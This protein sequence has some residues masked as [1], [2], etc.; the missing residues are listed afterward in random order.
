M[1]IRIGTRMIG[2]IGLVGSS[3]GQ[4]QMI[5]ADEK[6]YMELIGQI[7]DFIATKAVEVEAAEKREILIRVLERIMDRLEQSILVLASDGRVRM[8]NST[9][10]K[11]LR[12]DALSG[13]M[14]RIEETGDS[15]GDQNE[16]RLKVENKTYRVMGQSYSLGEDEGYSRLLIFDETKGFRTLFVKGN[17]K[18]SNSCSTGLLWG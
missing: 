10:K 16:Y 1:P 4:K 5:L 2:V 8:A 11:Q 18:Q 15:I 3:I 14:I 7:T 9:A 13:A 17:R 6:M 12:C